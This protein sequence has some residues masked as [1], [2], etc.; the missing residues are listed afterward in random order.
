MLQQSFDSLHDD[1]DASA[2]KVMELEEELRL[3]RSKVEAGETKYKQLLAGN[4]ELQN[5]QHQSLESVQS[6]E[7]KQKEASVKV[8]SLEHERDS[9]QQQ[10]DQIKKQLQ[11][12]SAGTQIW[13]TSSCV[14]VGSR[15]CC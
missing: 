3:E 14:A 10:I 4:E 9:R 6:L 13:T 1:L 15:R 11:Q 8:M 12:V 2:Q 7:K 5:T